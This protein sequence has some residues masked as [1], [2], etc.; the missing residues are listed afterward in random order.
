MVAVT[1]AGKP[2]KLSFVCK[3]EDCAGH[4]FEVL[5]EADGLRAFGA[6]G[7]KDEPPAFFGA[8]DPAMQEVLA[9]GMQPAN[10]QAGAVQPKSE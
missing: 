6:L 2:Y 9:K 5:F 3:P 7:G 4:R 8:P 1:I 10:S